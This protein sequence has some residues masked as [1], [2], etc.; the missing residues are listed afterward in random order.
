MSNSTQKRV[1]RVSFAVDGYVEIN[2]GEEM[3]S[4]CNCIGEHV[5]GAFVMPP[6]VRLSFMDWEDLLKIVH[7][8]PEETESIAEPSVSQ[9]QEAQ[10]KTALFLNNGGEVLFEIDSFRLHEGMLCFYL[11]KKFIVAVN[12][13]TISH[14]GPAEIKMNKPAEST[15]RVRVW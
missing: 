9:E 14:F 2:T 8:E 15:E 5:Q 12:P 4:I 7:N 13:Q 11:H 6:D 10:T 1:C 3:D